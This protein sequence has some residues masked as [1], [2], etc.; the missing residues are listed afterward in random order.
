MA[1]QDSI[2][3]KII[4]EV[5]RLTDEYLSSLV[6]KN[7]LASNSRGIENEPSDKNSTILE[8]KIKILY[9]L[10]GILGS[11][12]KESREKIELFYTQLYSANAT[13][14]KHHDE[15]WKHFTKNAALILGIILTGILPGLLVVGAI[16]L[17]GYSPKLWQ[18]SGQTFF[19]QAKKEIES[20][21]PDLSPQ[22]VPGAR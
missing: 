9:G 17:T 18:S 19:Q 7:S 3:L 21:R 13:L 11:K 8:Q 6:K 4:K 15:G 12:K 2:D 14:V 1:S 22:L 16:A 5:A 20:N 10:Q